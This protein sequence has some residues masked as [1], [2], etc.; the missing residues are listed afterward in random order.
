MSDD[1]DYE[2][3]QVCAIPCEGSCAPGDSC[4]EQ[5]E[6]KPICTQSSA[7]MT[8]CSLLQRAESINWGDM[9]IVANLLCTKSCN[10]TKNKMCGISTMNQSLLLINTIV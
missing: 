8:F 1:P 9:L 5:A 3:G 7:G 6:S 2:P 10:K 4:E